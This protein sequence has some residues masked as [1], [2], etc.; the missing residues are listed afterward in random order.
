MTSQDSQQKRKCNYNIETFIR[1][2]L[3][4]QYQ[5]YKMLGLNR[6]LL[7]FYS[8]SRKIINTFGIYTIM[9]VEDC[10]KD[11]ELPKT[12]RVYSF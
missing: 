5:N 12:F 1:R 3:I 2:Y 8:R 9:D 11:K 4:N 7:N 6:T 10:V